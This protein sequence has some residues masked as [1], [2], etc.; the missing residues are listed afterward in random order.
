MWDWNMAEHQ[1]TNPAL[2]VYPAYP[3]AVTER[4]KPPRRNGDC[5]VVFGLAIWSALLLPASFIFGDIWIPS[6]FTKVWH[7][8]KNGYWIFINWAHGYRTSRCWLVARL[9]IVARKI[10]N[11][12]APLIS[13]SGSLWCEKM[14]YFFFLGGGKHLLNTQVQSTSSPSKNQFRI[15]FKCH[16]LKSSLKM[17]ECI[18]SCGTALKRSTL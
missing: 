9:A 3:T 5:D 10:P 11:Y 16:Q 15:D 14:A 6:D 17:Y 7:D 4:T 1:P 12:S 8:W 13:C 2:L 18:L